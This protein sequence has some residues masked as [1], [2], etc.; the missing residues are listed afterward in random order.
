MLIFDETNLDT[1]T[2]ESNEISYI[3]RKQSS[4]YGDVFSIYF[5]LK[6]GIKL[7]WTYE[8]IELQTE[9]LEK[10]REILGAKSI[11]KIKL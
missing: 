11:N 5:Q 4:G 1:Y 9:A 7:E 10:I 3:Y 8:S 2:I 6:H